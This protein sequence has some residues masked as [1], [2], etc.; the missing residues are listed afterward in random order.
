MMIENNCFGGENYYP[1]VDEL[2]RAY[3]KVFKQLQ[4]SFRKGLLSCLLE[5]T[6][7]NI[8]QDWF[9]NILLDLISRELV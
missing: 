8:R 4:E 1:L 5:V 7:E 9:T 2:L 6:A 3:P